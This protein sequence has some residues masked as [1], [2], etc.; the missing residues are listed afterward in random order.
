MNVLFRSIHQQLSGGNC[1]GM[2]AHDRQRCACVLLPLQRPLRLAAKAVNPDEM[3]T[4]VM[5]YIQLGEYWYRLRALQLLC[6]QTLSEPL[7][8]TLS[9]EQQLGCPV[10]IYTGTLCISIIGSS[11]LCAVAQSRGIRNSCVVICRCH[12][13]LPRIGDFCLF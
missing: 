9:T 11:C 5:V 7:F 2:L 10:C 1:S 13:W 12:C 6:H 8:N 4:A 3:N